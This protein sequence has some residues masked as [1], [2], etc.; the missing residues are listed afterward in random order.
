MIINR[1]ALNIGQTRKLI[2][3]IEVDLSKSPFY[4]KVFKC[5][6]I[7][8]EATLFENGD[9]LS[10][11]LKVSADLVLECAVSLEEVP[12]KLSFNDSIEISDNK[13]DVDMYYFNKNMF[14]IDD[15]IIALVS[16]N[17]PSAITKK[18][19]KLPKDVKGVRFL[20]EEEAYEEMRNKNS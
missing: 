20:T 6:P 4:A 19:A 5:S 15:I 16:L 14:S 7:H 12:Y 3:D 2:D 8:V 1:G 18:G 10:I 13:D 17:I 9:F 11:D